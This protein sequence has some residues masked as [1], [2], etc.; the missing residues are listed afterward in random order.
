MTSYILVVVPCRVGKVVESDSHF[1]QVFPYRNCKFLPVDLC[2][3]IAL[4]QWP[5]HVVRALT[6]L[7]P[8]NFYFL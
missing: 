2:F 4:V 7:M 5:N 1:L 3:D 8:F 6:G